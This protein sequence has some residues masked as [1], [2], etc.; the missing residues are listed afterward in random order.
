MAIR[1]YRSLKKIKK[2]LYIPDNKGSWKFIVNNESNSEELYNI[3]SKKFVFGKPA[4]R[5]EKLIYENWH[6]RM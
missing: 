3:I 5:K 4:L 2:D 6:N 1:T